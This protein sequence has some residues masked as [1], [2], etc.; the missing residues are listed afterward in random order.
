MSQPPAQGPTETFIAVLVRQYTVGA[1][2]LFNG[3][4]GNPGPPVVAVELQPTGV[5]LTDLPGTISTQWIGDGRTLRY[6]EIR[7]AQAVR[8]SRIYLARAPSPHEMPFGVRLYLGESRSHLLLFTV[9]YEAL[10]DALESH[11]VPVDRSP[12]T[13]GFMLMGRK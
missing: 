9:D 2:S 3:G 7:A 13:L 11:H 8:N 1:F 4:T 5:V 12:R 6:P 10:L